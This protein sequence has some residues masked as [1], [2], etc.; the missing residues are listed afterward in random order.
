[1]HQENTGPY[2]P[3]RKVCARYDIVDRTLD[4]WLADPAMGFPRPIV[5]NTRRYF[6]EPELV[7]WERRRAGKDP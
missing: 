4:R 1:M 5:I 6:S 2:Q 3:A 7:A